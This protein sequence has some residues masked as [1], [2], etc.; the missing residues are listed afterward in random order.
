MNNF[1]D[2][3][4]V[5]IVNW[6]GRKYISKCLDS[7]RKQVYKE[8]SITLVDNG[9]DDGSVEYIR[10]NYPEVKIISLHKNYGFAYANNIA[11][12]EGG[13][14]FIAL[15]NNDAV[16][17]P[18]WLYA[19][20][21]EMDKNPEAGFAAS[22]MLFY[23]DKNIIDR[24]GDAYTA[25]ASGFLTG[26]GESADK[27]ISK[28]WIFG[29]CAGAAIYRAGMFDVVGLFDE[30]FFLVYEDV[31]LSFR[32]QLLGYR[33][34]YVPN[35]IVYHMAGR[36]IGYNSPVS[37][38]FGHRNLEWVWIHNMPASLIKK[39]FLPHCLYVAAAFFYFA[40]AGRMME[41][42]KAKLDAVKGLPAALKKR[43]R[44][45]GEKITDDE[46]IF[47]LFQKELWPV[48]FMRHLKK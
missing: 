8:F 45:Q 21:E 29:A 32:A 23:H 25:S 43:R 41:Y 22:K 30:D 18:L 34:L 35:A 17:D 7:L 46:Y 31:D 37:V 44:I 19:L 13:A 48:R 24:A 9:S 5:I 3:I 16:A 33:C 40:A 11:I 2:K 28:E 15:L 39:I 27:Y 38:Y 1:A 4:R 10:W 12:K 42:L 36:S 26:R 20:K 14:E 47:S 6:N